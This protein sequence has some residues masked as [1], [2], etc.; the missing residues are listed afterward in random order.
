MLIILSTLK[1]CVS[2]NEKYK[3]SP[4]YKDGKFVNAYPFKMEVSYIKSTWEWIFG[5]DKDRTPKEPLPIIRLKT[6]DFSDPPSDEI[7]FV[8]LGHSSIILEF[9]KKR[10][11]FDPVLSR[12]ASPYQWIGPKRF[13]PS[14]IDSSNLPK[15]NAVIISHD[16]YDHLDRNVIES[17]AGS[18]VP[19]IVPLAVGKHLEDWGIPKTRIIELDWWEESIL[20]NIKIVSVPS[21]HFSGRGVFDKDETQWC[22]LVLIGKKYKIY[23]SGDTGYSPVFQEISSRFAPFDLTFIKIGAYDKLWPWIH[24][25]PEEAVKIHQQLMGEVLV[26]IHWGTFNLGRHSWYSPIERLVIAA[27]KSGIKFFTPKIGEI[28]LKKNHKSAYWWRELMK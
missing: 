21:R 27:K 10:F 25:N 7:K 17:L 16:H 19:F 6:T 11:L 1:G 18:E 22:S 28:V 3:D 12:R 23:F 24:L 13:H 9:E 14:P 5:G 26:P 15:L 20:E 8:W 4:N 2:M